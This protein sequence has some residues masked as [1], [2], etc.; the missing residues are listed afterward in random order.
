MQ[1][2]SLATST[3]HA[4][5]LSCSHLYWCLTFMFTSDILY[6]VNAVLDLICQACANVTEM[7]SVCTVT[8][9]SYVK[10][11][12]SQILLCY[13]YFLWFG[14]KRGFFVNSNE[15]ISPFICVSVSFLYFY[16]MWDAD[17][18]WWQETCTQKPDTKKLK[19][20]TQF[21]LTVAALSDIGYVSNL[22]PWS[23]PNLTEKR[24][25]G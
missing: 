25:F 15:L 7:S 24:L 22:G 17:T 12:V 6:V 8:T 23:G 18:N 19:K 5:M 4:L 14:F 2:P 1:L 10:H 9:M 3:L 11:S 13:R 16:W 21:I 20:H